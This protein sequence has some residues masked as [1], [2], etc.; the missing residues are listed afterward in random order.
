MA[1]MDRM[2]I[3][4]VWG[5]REEQNSKR[6]QKEI[7]NKAPRDAGADGRYVSNGFKMAFGA[8][9]YSYA[10]EEWM[11]EHREAVPTPLGGGTIAHSL[12]RPPL[13]WPRATIS[14][15]LGA[16]LSL[17][18]SWCGPIGECIWW[19]T[20]VWTVGW[21]VFEHREAVPT[22][23]GGGTITHS[24]IPDLCS[25]GPVPRYPLLRSCV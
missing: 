12:I 18:V 24:L 17:T 25:P 13:T 5:M 16:G 1:H 20:R 6:A 14:V 11:F 8:S 4:H 10:A 2:I 21:S 3:V 9:P 7:S 22:P 15:T 19:A 23:P